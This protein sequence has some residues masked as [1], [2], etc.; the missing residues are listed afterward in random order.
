[1]NDATFCCKAPF[2][3]SH[4]CKQVL[5]LNCADLF[6]KFSCFVCAFFVCNF[7]H[8]YTFILSFMSFLSEFCFLFY[9]YSENQN[10]S[11]YTL[12]FSLQINQ[13]NTSSVRFSG[14]RQNVARLFAIML[15]K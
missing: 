1:M 8:Y 14:L 9:K 13:F 15:P 2:L 7:I 11:S 4:Y 10:Q 3:L 6:K 5:L 12:K